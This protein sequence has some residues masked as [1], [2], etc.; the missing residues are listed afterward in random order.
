MP[1]KYSQLRATLALALHLQSA[2]RFFAVQSS[3]YTRIWQLPVQLAGL[4]IWAVVIGLL[5]VRAFKWE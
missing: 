4:S 5:A 3:L 1:E 2:V